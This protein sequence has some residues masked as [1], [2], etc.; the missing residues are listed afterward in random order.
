MIKKILKEA[1]FC[2]VCESE[3][4][5]PRMVTVIRGKEE[6][7]FCRKHFNQIQIWCDNHKTDLFNTVFSDMHIDIFTAQENNENH[8]VIT[9]K[10]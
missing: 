3:I 4:Q 1:Y 6:K 8:K 10:H 9:L 5:Q 2:E 7:H